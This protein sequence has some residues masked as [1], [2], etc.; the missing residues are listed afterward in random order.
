MSWVEKNKKLIIGGTTIGHQREYIQRKCRFVIFY[1]VLCS[2]SKIVVFTISNRPKIMFRICFFKRF[3]ENRPNCVFAKY[4][5]KRKCVILKCD[6]AVS[7]KS[8]P[9]RLSSYATNYHGNSTP[10]NVPRFL[11]ALKC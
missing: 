2:F 6:Q 9:A 5:F 1:K 11:K 3:Q 4:L 10:L 8:T 7:V